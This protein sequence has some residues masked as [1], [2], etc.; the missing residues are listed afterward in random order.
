MR[1]QGKKPHKG[2]KTEEKKKRGALHGSQKPYGKKQNSQSP[3]KTKLLKPN[4]YGF[5][6]VSHAWINKKR[7]IQKLYITEQAWKGFEEYYNQAQ[8]QNLDRPEPHII[9]KETL[10]KT[11]PKNTVHQGIAICCSPLEEIA[12][13]D[14][15][16]QDSLHN[17]AS[18]TAQEATQENLEHS[19]KPSVILMLDQVTDPHNVG[20]IIRTACAL[21]AKG[22]IMQKKHAPELQTVLA[23][24]ACGGIEYLPIAYETNLSRS[25]EALKEKHYLVF[26]LD[27]HTTCKLPEHSQ[28][29]SNSCTAPSQ[30]KIVL[31][32]GAEDS[33]I[34]RLLKEK[35]DGLISLPTQKPIQ[36]LNVSNAGAIALYK[37]LNP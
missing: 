15:I 16:I 21:G 31:I 7:K 5:H 19:K 17:D 32:L 20:A 28:Q 27:E 14:I 33:G 23:K 3:Q 8:S 25:I 11:L 29:N 18:N 24:T 34:R 12:L 1:K 13:Q 37:F 2:R 4:I 10:D 35:C 6:A 36:S 30:Q 26:G 9:E 22:I